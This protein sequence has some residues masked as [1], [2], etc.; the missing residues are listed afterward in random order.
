MIAQTNVLTAAQAA[1]VAAASGSGGTGAAAGGAAAGGAGGG[2]SATTIAIVA[3]AVAG[4]A[5]AAQQVVGGDDVGGVSIYEGDFRIDSISTVQQAQPNGVIFLTCTQTH[6]QIGE[7]RAEI[8]EREDGALIGTMSAK[9][10]ATELSTTCPFPSGASDISLGKATVT[11]TKTGFQASS[12]NTSADGSFGAQSFSGA[13]ANGVIT[14]T[15]TLG[16]GGY[17]GSNG[18]GGGSSPAGSVAVRLTK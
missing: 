9:W 4:G 18:F 3:G 16:P 12:Q 17:R 10:N 5:V 6:S 1:G 8:E 7:V 2:I 15:W 13:L 11:G 14:G